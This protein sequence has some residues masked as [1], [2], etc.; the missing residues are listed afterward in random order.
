[1]LLKSDEDKT[2]QWGEDMSS[3]SPVETTPVS[4]VIF[5]KQIKSPEKTEAKKEF[6][7]FLLLKNHQWDKK[8]SA[9]DRIGD[10]FMVS[11]DNKKYKMIK[12]INHC[13]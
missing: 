8:G 11:V 12:A 9:K 5:R 13:I 2:G 7:L 1:M 4:L 10:F 3:A 6:L